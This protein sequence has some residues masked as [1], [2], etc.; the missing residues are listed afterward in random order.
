MS[1]MQDAKR[2]GC[3]P[4][5]VPRTYFPLRDGNRVTLYH[6][7]VCNP[8]PVEGVKLADGQLFQENSCWDDVIDAID[9]AQRCASNC[10]CNILGSSDAVELSA[11]C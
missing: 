5:E 10:Y 9:Q 11:A 2:S 3:E 6:D 1:V 7:S 4:Y 8:G